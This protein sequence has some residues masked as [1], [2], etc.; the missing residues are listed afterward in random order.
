RQR[1]RANG[2]HY[3]RPPEEPVRPQPFETREYLLER[4]PF[5]LR[6]RT[7]TRCHRAPS[8]AMQRR[9]NTPARTAC[10]CARTWSPAHACLRQS[11]TPTTACLLP[12]RAPSDGHHCRRRTTTPRLSRAFRCSTAP[13]T[14]TATPACWSSHRA[15]R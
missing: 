12:N 1:D 5:F 11:G 14:D 3:G 10:P 9:L 13:A 7:A 15:R 4:V 8:R 6:V 2:G